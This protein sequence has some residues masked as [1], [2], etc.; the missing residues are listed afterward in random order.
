[1]SSVID[2]PFDV[3][4]PYPLGECAEAD[5][6]RAPLGIT[7]GPFGR[8]LVGLVHLR[9]SPEGMRIGVEVDQATANAMLFGSVVLT[10]VELNGGE[11]VEGALDGWRLER[12]TVAYRC[13]PASVHR[14]GWADLPLAD[15]ER[16]WDADAADNR[17]AG[18]CAVDRA[19][20]DSSP[21]DWDCYASAHL[22][23]DDEADPHT[24]R[25]YRMLIV[26]EVDGRRVIVP[27]AVFTAAGVLQG[28]RGG[29]DAPSD[30]IEAM[31]GVLSGLYRRMA[32]AWDDASVR[33]PWDAAD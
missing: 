25:A 28:A 3:S 19:G 12:A 7:R 10:D 31:R 6:H 18:A 23:R 9:S 17:I 33:A 4:G 27:R 14:D 15:R 1:M 11:I 16:A 21:A 13:V 22:Y 2:L 26:D 20:V 29:I 32:D 24:R 30:A 8:D 5:G